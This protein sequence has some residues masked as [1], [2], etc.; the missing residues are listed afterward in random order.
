MADV[1]QA[2]PGSNVDSLT[3]ATGIATAMAAAGYLPPLQTPFEHLALAFSGGG[4][5]AAAFSLG[6]LSYLNVVDFPDDHSATGKA[7]LLQKIRYM[8]SASGGT[9]T[10]ASFALACAEGKSFQEMFDGLYANL[11]GQGLLTQA[12]TFLN[13]KAPWRQRPDKRRN[14]INAFAL[15]YDQL[16]FQGKKLSALQNGGGAA[17]GAAGGS[18]GGA[19]GGMRVPLEEVCFNTTEF[20]RGLPFRQNIKIAADSKADAHFYFGNFIFHVPAATAG[21]ILLSDA[22]AA[23]SC[24]PAGFEPLKFP[25]DLAHPGLPKDQLLKSVECNPDQ[26]AP[27]DI[28]LLHQKGFGL[29][30][31]GITDNQGLESLMLADLRRQKKE[32]SFMPFDLALINDVGS[33]YMEPYE[34][35]TAGHRSLL[36]RLSYVALRGIFIFLPILAIVLAIWSW[37]AASPLWKAIMFAG[38]V[39]LA[40]LSGVFWAID[41]HVPTKHTSMKPLNNFSPAVIGLLLRFFGRTRLSILYQMIAARVSSTIILNADVFLKRIRKLIYDAFFESPHWLFRRKAN[42]VY[43]LAPKNDLNRINHSTANSPQLTKDIQTVAGMAFDVPTTLWFGM[44]DTPTL[45]CL[46]ACG[47]FT[48]CYNLQEYLGRL[49]SD[50]AVY[51]ALDQRYKDRCEAIQKKLQAD[52]QQFSK[53]PFFYYNQYHPQAKLR[54]TGDAVKPFP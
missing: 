36:G 30:D 44:D 13:H 48:T 53:D 50:K 28:D 3:S 17:G 49:M 37:H 29:M 5:R 43:D 38:A 47:E 15:S 10:A 40:A 14:L 4:F 26:L 54:V 6:V 16:L 35:P 41:W 18:G 12:L 1:L 8:S 21:N 25:E 22:L 27:G 34:V 7:S 11:D 24:F 2:A 9:I 51:D 52:W 39:L 46:V 45:A 32:T 23:S 20:F 42:H 33:H 31:G 19:A